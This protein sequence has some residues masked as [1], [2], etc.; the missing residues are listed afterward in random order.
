[1]K[2]LG[3]QFF[4]N[5]FQAHSFD[6]RV[7]VKPAILLVDGCSQFYS[8]FQQLWITVRHSW[9][10]E[11]LHNSLQQAITKLLPPL[12]SSAIS[13]KPGLSRTDTATLPGLTLLLSMTRIR[14]GIIVRMQTELT[15]CRT[16][17]LL[18]YI[19]SSSATLRAHGILL[20]STSS[21]LLGIRGTPRTHHKT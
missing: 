10:A 9:V 16:G 21:R 1:M 6:H 17:N 5:E 13:L 7:I 2:L 3:Q 19:S 12:R 14:F 8:P 4:P 20:V 11:I 18:N 15:G